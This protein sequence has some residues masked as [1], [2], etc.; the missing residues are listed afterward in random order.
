MKKMTVIMTALF[1][2]ILFA[3][4]SFSFGTNVN[5]NVN[6]ANTNANTGVQPE[7][8]PATGGGDASAAAA[9]A[10]VADLYKAHEGK[11]SPFFQT[12]DRA[13]VD[14]YFAKQLADL[15]WKDATSTKDEVGAIDADPLYN[16]QD[17]DIKNFAVGKAEINGN[18]AKVPV[19]FTNF[20]KKVT[21]TFSLTRVGDNWRIDNILYGGG[22]SL[23]KWLKE[24]YSGQ[25]ETSSSNEFEGKYQVGETTCTVTPSKMSF[26]VRWAKGSGVETYFYKDGN[27][28]E[29]SNKDGSSNQFV[30]DDSNYNSGTFNRSSDGKSLPVRRIK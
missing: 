30:F 21:V 26:D 19:T 17:T 4:C 27:T 9:E 25:N 16:A 20:G 28:F 10:L 22:D 13:L 11:H 7:G 23:L 2:A 1:S 15:I 8:T 6:A 5:A 3:S 18:A 29:S 12:K 24:T 14:K